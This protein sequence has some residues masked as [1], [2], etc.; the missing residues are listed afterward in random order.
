MH[1][2]AGG[3]SLKERSE[4]FYLDKIR[5]FGCKFEEKLVILKQIWRKKLAK[6]GSSLLK[7]L[8]M[9]GMD[10]KNFKKNSRKLGSI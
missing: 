6:F 2:L 9:D 3:F 1:H 4:N 8:H 7:R 5:L 10:L